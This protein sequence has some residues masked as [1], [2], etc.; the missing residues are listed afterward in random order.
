MKYVVVVVISLLVGVGLGF[1][2]EVVTLNGLI[3]ACVAGGIAAVAAVYLLEKVGLFLSKQKKDINRSN[4]K[5]EKG[6]SSTF[7]RKGNHGVRL[8]NWIFAN[9]QMSSLTP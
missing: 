7:D 5:N 3:L 9:A 4:S 8:G 1:K 2:D 6:Q